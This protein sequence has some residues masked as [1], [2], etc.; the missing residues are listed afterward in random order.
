[1]PGSMLP[2][3]HPS[4]QS[5]QVGQVLSTKLTGGIH[6]RQCSANRTLA[7]LLEAPTVRGLKR[8]A[9][10]NA[11][12]LV[13]NP[14]HIPSPPRSRISCDDYRS[15][16]HGLV[17]LVLPDRQT[18]LNRIAY[19]LSVCPVAPARYLQAPA[20]SPLRRMRET[21]THQTSL[22]LCE[23]PHSPT[24]VTIHTMSHV[25]CPMCLLSTQSQSTGQW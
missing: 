24:H 12:W 16:I 5:D 2:G 10:G 1:M 15:R 3:S 4:P 17:W 18:F 14:R 8:C 6:T 21:K 9:S 19:S 11:S 23:L 22:T 25:P 7:L 13:A 20:S